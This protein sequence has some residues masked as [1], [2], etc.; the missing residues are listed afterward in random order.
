M[1]G[2]RGWEVIDR[3]SIDGVSGGKEWEGGWGRSDLGIGINDMPI[4]YR[5]CSMGPDIVHTGFW[6]KEY[7]DSYTD[8]PLTMKE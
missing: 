2:C 6:A 5:K 3:F 8:I 4:I 1:D 7:G